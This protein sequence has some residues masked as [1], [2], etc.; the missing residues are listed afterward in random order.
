MQT[1]D[2]S[3]NH[4]AWRF[5]WRAMRKPGG[6]IFLL[7]LVTLALA[8]SACKK[9]VALD[10]IETDANGYL[11]LKCGVKLYTDRSVFIGPKC[12]KCG[13][14]TLMTVV[15]YYC[16][17]DKHLTIRAQRGDPHGPVCEQCQA[18]L[19]NAMRS[20]REKDLKSWGATK[21]SS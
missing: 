13:E 18:P 8:A 3:H 15:G 21:V 7:C 11:C 16:D 10:A 6:G 1:R 19:A 20:P 2:L 9:D 17:K 12:P 4:F 5:R 14:D